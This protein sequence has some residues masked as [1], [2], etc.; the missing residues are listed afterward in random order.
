MNVDRPT[1]MWLLIGTSFASLTRNDISICMIPT[2][3]H[4]GESKKGKENKL[5]IGTLLVPIYLIYQYIYWYLYVTMKLIQLLKILNTLSMSCSFAL[6]DWMM[7]TIISF[8][9]YFFPLMI[10]YWMMMMITRDCIH[11]FFRFIKIGRFEVGSLHNKIF[12]NLC[13]VKFHNA[14]V[15]PPFSEEFSSIFLQ[16]QHTH[17]FLFPVR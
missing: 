8:Y 13:N 10:K 7:I 15:F 3:Q 6:T 11:H 9:H 14:R 1:H 5:N 16:S 12:K 2:L 17:F 4:A